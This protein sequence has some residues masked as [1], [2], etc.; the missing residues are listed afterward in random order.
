MGVQGGGTQQGGPGADPGVTVKQ[1]RHQRSGTEGPDL[2]RVP[3]TPSESC[4]REIFPTNS[5]T[6]L[7]SM[8]G[9]I[10]QPSLGTTAA[11]PPLSSSVAQRYPAPSAF[12]NIKGAIFLLTLATHKSHSSCHS[13]SLSEG[14]RQT[15]PTR[16]CSRGCVLT[17][18]D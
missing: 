7:I 14:H 4:R 16:S 1:A 11:W 18:I 8:S 15:P 10:P 13:W 2:C 6:L 17:N 12:L 9:H 3:C 5:Q